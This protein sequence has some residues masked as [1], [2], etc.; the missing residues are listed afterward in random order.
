MR[1]RV[2]V[3]AEAAPEGVARELGARHEWH[4]RRQSELHEKV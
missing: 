1:I 3:R 2:E 4:A